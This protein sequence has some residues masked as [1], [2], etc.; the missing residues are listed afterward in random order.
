MGISVSEDFF[1]FFQVHQILHEFDIKLISDF[2]LNL[3][4]DNCIKDTKKRI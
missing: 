3:Y 1:A 2:T 4:T